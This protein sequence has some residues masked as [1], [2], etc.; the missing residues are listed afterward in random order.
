MPTLV[1]SAADPLGRACVAAL[2]RSG[3]EVRAFLDP[4][5]A[6]A[7]ATQALRGRGVKVAEGT[8]DDEGQLELACEQVHT[9][10]HAPGVLSAADAVLDDTATVVSAALGAGCRRLVV[11]SHLGAEAPGDNDWLAAL[12]TAE[13]LLAE[14]PID[15]V[16]LRRSLTYGP[17][18][19]VTQLIA[20]GAVGADL[21]AVHQPLWVDDL[22][23]AVVA[24]DA[25]DR[26]LGVL[27][28]LLLPLVGPQACNLGELVALL[29]GQVTGGLRSS[30]ARA[31]PGTPHTAAHVL[32][33]LSRDLS[34]PKD[35]P[36]GGTSPGQGAELVRA[37]AA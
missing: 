2:Q 8:A 16:V 24:A 11:V 32:D 3:G 7:G 20:D 17:W 6:P 4:D 22:A 37:S 27:P 35:A 18:D 30:I 10:I 23:A 28:H 33:L 19:P 34:G 15:T 25:R 31:R 36:A 26:D 13:E 21:E 12:A 9:V 14:A 29:G 1:T 5:L